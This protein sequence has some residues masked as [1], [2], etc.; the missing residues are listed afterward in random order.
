MFVYFTPANSVILVQLNWVTAAYPLG[1]SLIDWFTEFCWVVPAWPHLMIT[2][3]PFPS[4]PLILSA[5][6]PTSCCT[7]QLQLKHF[8]S[9]EVWLQKHLKGEEVKSGK[10]LWKGREILRIW[11]L[12]SY[13]IDLHILIMFHY[14]S[15]M[16]WLC[17]LKLENFHW[18]KGCHIWWCYIYAVVFEAYRLTYKNLPY[19]S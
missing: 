15:E 17:S 2:L 6:Q 4:S 18:E 13:F 7:L 5:L 10:Q 12:M 3:L 9:N 19:T 1:L 14:L 8:H 11:F 16:M